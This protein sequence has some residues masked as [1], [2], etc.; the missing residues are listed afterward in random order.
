MCVGIP[1]MPFISGG[2]N[3]LER[4]TLWRCVGIPKMPLI[5]GGFNALERGTLW[6]CVG[7]PK[8]PLISGGFNALQWLAKSASARTHSLEKS[9]PLLDLAPANSLTELSQAYTGV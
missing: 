6:R 5:S 7:I 3:A 9:A 8:M 1:K 2:F 4:G